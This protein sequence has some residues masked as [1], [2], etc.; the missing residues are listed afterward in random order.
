MKRIWEVGTGRNIN[1]QVLIENYTC[2][3]DLRRTR[4]KKIEASTIPNPERRL[5]E[6]KEKE[7]IK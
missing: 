5:K 4:W 1:D 6:K 3:L 7:I 2:D